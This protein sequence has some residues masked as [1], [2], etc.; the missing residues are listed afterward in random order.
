MAEIYILVPFLLFSEDYIH[1]FS[2]CAFHAFISLYY[3]FSLLYLFNQC[4]VILRFSMENIFYSSNSRINL[5]FINAFNQ[6]VTA[7]PK[8]GAF[9]VKLDSNGSIF[10]QFYD[11]GDLPCSLDNNCRGN[12]IRWRHGVTNYTN[13]LVTTP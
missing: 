10:R 7:P 12:A 13:I 5:Y 1:I 3:L 6:A 11:R 2:V 9:D 8:S 4:L